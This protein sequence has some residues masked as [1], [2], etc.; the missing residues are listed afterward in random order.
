MRGSC[1][2]WRA[3]ASNGKDVRIGSHTIRRLK[4]TELPETTVPLARF[5]IGKI[6]VR[7]LPEGML[8]GRI[9]ETEAYLQGDAACHAFNGMTPR[10]RSLYLE[11]GHAY[12]YLAYGTSWML[13]V[14]SLKAGEGEGVLIRALEPIAGM[15]IMARHRRTEAP[16]D[17]ARGPG[18]VAQALRI[19]RGLDGVD[20]TRNRELWLGAEVVGEGAISA[21]SIG[22]STRIGLTKDAH[23]PLRFFSKGSRFVSGPGSLNR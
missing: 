22:T 2:P 18:R 20:L 8:A 21:A 12:V 23:R 1:V 16:R 7:M 14:A 6:V 4:R 11:R 10:N 15:D 19:D 17:L 3:A 13:N 5:L 9:V